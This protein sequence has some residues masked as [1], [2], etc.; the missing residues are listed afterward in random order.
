MVI[1]SFASIGAVVTGDGPSSRP[2]FRGAA[3][4]EPVPRRV[5]VAAPAPRQNI[6]APSPVRLEPTSGLAFGDQ[7]GDALIAIASK[8]PGFPS[9]LTGGRSDFSQTARERC[10]FS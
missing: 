9:V 7:I 6:P 1:P 3:F 8:P 5:S 4:F 2:A 10:G